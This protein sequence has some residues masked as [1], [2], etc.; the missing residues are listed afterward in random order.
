MTEQHRSSRRSA[1]IAAL[2]VLI[3]LLATACGGE[4]EFGSKDLL[5]FDD[6]KGQAG[7]QDTPTASPTQTPRSTPRSTSTQSPP[8]KSP[9]QG[10]EVFFDVTL[11]SDSPY[12][13]P[14]NQLIMSAG[15]TL[16]VTNRD[17][18]PERP[19][20]SFTAEDGSFDSG[21]LKPG[22]VWTRKFTQKG[23]WR[24]VDSRAGFIFATLEVR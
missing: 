11:T 2:M 5:K 20:R 19:T 3:A 24:I 8:K 21:P 12:F 14:G 16:R 9:T 13:A 7:I 17:T 23:S 22:Q 15:V 1:R 10:P 6:K 4:K 18:T